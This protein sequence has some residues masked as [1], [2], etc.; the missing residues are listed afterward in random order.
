MRLRIR[1]RVKRGQPLNASPNPN[2]KRNWNSVSAMAGCTLFLRDE[3][4]AS[5]RMAVRLMRTTVNASAV[6]RSRYLSTCVR[7]EAAE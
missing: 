7:A 1:S 5:S 4:A 3:L 6:V 2:P